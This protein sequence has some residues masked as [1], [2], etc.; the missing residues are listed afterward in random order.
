M[1]DNIFEVQIS[2]KPSKIAFYKHVLASANGLKTND[3]I[4]D[5]RQWLRY[6]AARRRGQAAYTIYSI[7]GF[8][9]AAYF[10]VIQHFIRHGNSVLASVYSICRQSVVQGVA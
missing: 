10:Q 6:V 2:P 8:T 3:A 4:E 5:W 7:G 1:A 9:A